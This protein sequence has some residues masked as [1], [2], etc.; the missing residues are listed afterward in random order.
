MKPSQLKAALMFHGMYRQPVIVLSAPGVGKSSIF[1]SVFDELGMDH[2]TVNLALSDGTDLKGMPSFVEHEGMKAIKWAKEAVFLR[3]SPIAIFLDEL[4][5]AQ[6][7]VMNAAA[8]I[9]LENRIDDV[10]LPAGS[11]VCGASNRIEDKAGV[12]RAPS[13]IPN[14]ATILPNLAIS[15]DE[16]AEYLLEGGSSKRHRG[17]YQ[18]PLPAPTTR[19]WRVA[20]YLRMKPDALSKFDASELIN[21]TPRQWEWVAQFNE[22]LPDQIAYD[23]IAGRVGEGNATGL[24]AFIKIQSKLPSKEEILLNPKK[25]KVP[26]EPSA[27]YLVTGMLAQASNATTFDSVCIYAERMPPEFQA[28]L[29][30]DAMRIAPEVTSTKAFVSWGVK[31]AEVLR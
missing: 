4:F 15:V 8:P 13:H 6:T 23:V 25:C 22:V 16:W 7:Q 3:K 27:L 10:F 20:Q 26:E 24:R 31:F 11:W 5:Q 21:A 1:R 29:V 18:E 12:N 9:I 17:E 14:R 2:H 28:M 19:D 30:K